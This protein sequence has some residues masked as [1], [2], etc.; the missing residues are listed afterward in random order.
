MSVILQLF[1][2][3][4]TSRVVARSDMTNP[5]HIWSQRLLGLAS[6]NLP[7]G[8]CRR[9]YG[10]AGDISPDWP[11]IATC[12]SRLMSSNHYVEHSNLSVA[13]GEALRIA[14]TAR[15]KEV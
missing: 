1:L 14:S 5:F 3:R 2:A 9:P 4:Q 15:S 10:S 8:G 12:R 7:A 6:S 13:W 11:S